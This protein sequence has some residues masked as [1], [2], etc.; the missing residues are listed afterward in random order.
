MTMARAYGTRYQED[1][2]YYK[3]ERA[4]SEDNCVMAVN[5]NGGKDVYIKET[6]TLIKEITS[7]VR[8]KASTTDGHA[9]LAGVITSKDGFAVINIGD[10]GFSVRGR[11]NDGN[12][13]VVQ[14]TS[15]QKLP[16]GWVVNSIGKE[17]TDG[18]SDEI[19]AVT[20]EQLQADYGLY[21]PYEGILFT[22]GLVIGAEKVTGSA[23][24]PGRVK[25]S[26]SD[27]IAQ[28][29]SRGSSAA[30][31]ASL[32]VQGSIARD[33][34]K[35]RALVGDDTTVIVF[36]MPRKD[37]KQIAAF[38]SDGVGG[39]KG[40]EMTSS[41]A[42][43]DAARQLEKVTTN[44]YR[45]DTIL[46]VRGQNF[47]PRTHSPQTASS[48]TRVDLLPTTEQWLKRAA[49]FIDGQPRVTVA[50]YPKYNETA[51]LT[52][53]IPTAKKLEIAL[54]NAG[55]NPVYFGDYYIGLHGNDAK[56]F[57]DELNR[58]EAATNRQ[59]PRGR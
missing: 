30:D 15:P 2:R 29:C 21:P 16:I 27:R 56:K 23:D 48:V 34:E 19:K 52:Q 40:G 4:A 47:N 6:E 53:N 22:D 1:G 49:E 20:F 59:E 13:K 11:D 28:L 39:E 31:L 36:K 14:I 57:M 18:K 8:E 50:Q 25:A 7:Y 9:T 3:A 58:V 55:L 17:K 44:K 32:A 41:I 43:L 37:G 54:R 5:W 42:I 26:Q 10:S 38:L 35:Q 51:I 12:I 46:A 45:V 33:M 24:F